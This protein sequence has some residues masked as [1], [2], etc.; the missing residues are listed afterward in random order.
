M[1]KD[2]FV[3][4]IIYIITNSTYF[5]CVYRAL[6]GT[7]KGAKRTINIGNEVTR[8]SFLQLEIQIANHGNAVHAPPKYIAIDIFA[9]QVR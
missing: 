6:S 2:F 7:T 4:N 5:V 8:T 1:L 3:P 9:T